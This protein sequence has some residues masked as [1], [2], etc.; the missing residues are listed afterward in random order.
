MINTVVRVIK[1]SCVGCGSNLDISQD[2]NKLACGH[3]GTQQIVERSGG[4]IHLRGVAEALSKVQVGTDRTAAELA[5]TRLSKE[6]EYLHFERTEREQNWSNVRMQ[7]SYDLNSF[8]EEKKK[9]VNKVTILTAA[10]SFIALSI[11]SKL[12]MPI[13]FLLFFIASIVA[14][15]LVRKTM[16][17][18]DEYNPQKLQDE[19]NLELIKLDRQ[20]ARDLGEVDKR[21][22]EL[23]TRLHQNYQVANS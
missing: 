16:I 21:I 5:I 10:L 4:A 2:M 14:T 11:P 1:L 22:A 13:I 8:I 17:T 20:I 12:D 15:I 18:K 7:K 6:L 19:C 9:K 23:N 3:C